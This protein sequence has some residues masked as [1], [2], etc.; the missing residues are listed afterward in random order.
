MLKYF[1]IRRIERSRERLEG[2]IQKEQ[3]ELEKKRLK[4]QKEKEFR[5]FLEIAKKGE[6]LLNYCPNIY[7]SKVGK[8]L[9]DY[10]FKNIRTIGT[11][12]RDVGDMVL[13][14]EALIIEKAKKI[15]AEVVT[16]VKT[17]IAYYGERYN[18]I[19]LLRKKEEAFLSNALNAVDFHLSS[20]FRLPD[21]YFS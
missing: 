8:S 17:S 14:T 1:R 6:F 15:G 10:D 21:L 12:Y 16:N 3:E 2:K 9:D 5:Q 18:V 4:E 13:K 7:V 20:L 11:G 19:A